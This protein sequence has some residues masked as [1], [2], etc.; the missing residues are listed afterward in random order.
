MIGCERDDT[1]LPNASELIA[2]HWRQAA[3]L[4]RKV[5]I[6]MDNMIIS[7]AILQFEIVIRE[8]VKGSEFFEGRNYHS[9]GCQIWSQNAGSH[10]AVHGLL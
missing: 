10:C 1:H 9:I 2:I 6:R 5:R 3:D 7:D 8:T 4:D